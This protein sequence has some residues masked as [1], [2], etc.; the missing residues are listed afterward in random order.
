MVEQ[1]TSKNIRYDDGVRWN[2]TRGEKTSFTC[3]STR[4]ENV[5]E[6]T[7]GRKKKSYIIIE[8]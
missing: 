5:M 6:T 4:P 3:R 2:R 1:N 7:A 8:E